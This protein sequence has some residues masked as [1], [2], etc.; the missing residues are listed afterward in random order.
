MPATSSIQRYSK[1]GG[2]VYQWFCW[3]L[4]LGS[5]LER[6][7]FSHVRP[8]PEPG[9]ACEIHTLP[10]FDTMMEI[11]T[12]IIEI[13]SKKSSVHIEKNLWTPLDF[14]PFFRDIWDRLVASRRSFLFRGSAPTRGGCNIF[15]EDGKKMGCIWWFNGGFKEK[16]LPVIGL[17]YLKP[18]RMKK[19][20]WIGLMKT[21]ASYRFSLE[22]V[23]WQG[24]F[25]NLLMVWMKRRW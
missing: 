22:Q 5:D 2:M 8:W 16:H 19:G 11:S 9:A 10:S 21:M 20:H 15:C 13:S 4:T 18:I 25:T 6:P 3:D 24:C 14:A 17:V 23:H 12:K 7:Y 1:D